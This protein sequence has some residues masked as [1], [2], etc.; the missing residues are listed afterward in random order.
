MGRKAE[1]QRMMLEKLMGPEAMG[2][3]TA[4]LHFTDPKVCRN[5]LCGTCPHDLFANTKVDLGA[6]PKAHTPKYKDEYRKAL[7]A[8]QRFP[9]F[10]REHEHNIMAFIN[11]IDR[12][13]NTNKRRLEQTPEELARF[14]N[15]NREIAEIET[16]LAAVMA[17]VEALGEQGQIE[18]SLA[19]LAKADALKEEKAQKEE[20]LHKAQENSGAS[21]HQKLRVCDVCGAYLSILDSDRRLADHFGGKMHLGYLRL[22]EMISEF[23]ERR[24]HPNP[25]PMGMPAAPPATSSSN[26]HA[27]LPRPSLSAAAGSSAHRNGASASD[28]ERER[29]F[30]RERERRD[31]ERKESREQRTGSQADDAAKR[32]GEE[33]EL[34]E[35]EGEM[36]EDGPS[37]AQP[38]DEDRKRS[39][40]PSQRLDCRDTGEQERADGLPRPEKAPDSTWEA[41]PNFEKVGRAE[42]GACQPRSLTTIYRRRRRGDLAQPASRMSYFLPHLPTGWHVDQA[43]LSEEDR[44]VIIRF[45]HDTDPVC[46]E[47]DETLYKI[48]TAVQKFAVIYLV[49]TTQVPDFNKMYELYDACSVMFF[50]RNKHIMI[51][52]G[53]GNNNKINWAI[54][55]R[56]E[57]IDIVE[58][59][60]RGASKGRGLVIS[61]KEAALKFRCKNIGLVLI[62]YTL[63]AR[64]SK[65]APPSEWFDNC[66]A[67]MVKVKLRVPLSSAPRET[68]S[69]LANP[70]RSA[71]DYSDDEDNDTSPRP[72]N[73]G[74][75][76]E[77][78]DDDDDQVDEDDDEEDQ[79]ADELDEQDELEEEEGDNSRAPSAST[80]KR[81]SITIKSRSSRGGASSSASPSMDGSASPHSGSSKMVKR[82]SLARM[83]HVQAMTVEELDALPAAKRR[84]TAKARGAAG[85]GRG[86]RKGL[87]KGQKPVYELPPAEK[88]PATFGNTANARPSVPK[89]ETPTPSSFVTKSKPSS[90]L[91]ASAEANRAAAS[92]SAPTARASAATGSAAAT[93]IKIVAGPGGHTFTGDLSAKAGTAKNPG[94]RYP[95]LP[96]SRAGPPVQPLARIPT[97][98]QSVIPLERNGRQPR[99]WIKGKR[100]ILSMG[101]RPWSI[102]VLYGGD[103][104]GYEKKID[105]GT[106]VTTAA[107]AVAGAAAGEKIAS[108]AGTPA[109]AAKANSP[110]PTPV[111]TPTPHP[112]SVKPPGPTEGARTG[113][114]PLPPPKHLGGLS[115]VQAE[116]N[117]RG[118]SPAF[119]FG[120][121]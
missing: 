34:G 70:L 4:N 117:W 105:A 103:D 109:A 28:R 102:P 2:T 99:R 104:R 44:V 118:Q 5:F 35:E 67:T 89:A 96:S 55:E 112:T 56:Q 38:K 39:R 93:S 64:T 9:E 27:T 17:E 75:D 33:G 68:S 80:P 76:D 71:P 121:R 49:D 58:V 29:D 37:R 57:L 48:S 81:R 78:G 26:G 72:G 50:Y 15:M 74:H 77:G 65:L 53:T 61:P 69:P 79:E 84:K 13:I 90:T 19:E 12:K 119:L 87:T 1:V 43:I 36:V 54:T 41:A 47:M 114:S 52:L 3:P 113:S 10:E 32:G 92:S 95:P 108:K 24:R 11:D 16:A 82:T 40:S 42:F 86:W 94:F 120:G 107:G 7:A 110:T 25:P 115:A 63:Q 106:G 51:D 116:T 45:G 101:G 73:N 59:V 31:R 97:S 83:A 22:R 100:E 46:M 111:Q 14:A 18:E 60:Y 91:A 98:F 23:D 6:C 62:M 8:G 85:P 30:E 66:D 21:G 88:T 20:E